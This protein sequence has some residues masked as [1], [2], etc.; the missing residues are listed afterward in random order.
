MR[1]NISEVSATPL[2]AT[3][4]PQGQSVEFFELVGAPPPPSQKNTYQ[5][6][7]LFIPPIN[8]KIS[9]SWLLK[10]LF[11]DH[12]NNTGSKQL[13]VFFCQNDGFPDGIFNGYLWSVPRYIAICMVTS[14]L[15]GCCMMIMFHRSVSQW[16]VG[17]KTMPSEKS[18]RFCFKKMYRLKLKFKKGNSPTLKSVHLKKLHSK[19]KLSRIHQPRKIRGSTSPTSLGDRPGAPAV[20]CSAAHLVS[21]LPLLKPSAPSAVHRKVEG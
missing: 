12:Q 17:R 7:S 14:G 19:K 9:T 15:S 8:V 13:R 6:L 20:S 5:P 2:V 3:L 4:Q 11:P 1:W 10:N 18:S 16:S 21:A